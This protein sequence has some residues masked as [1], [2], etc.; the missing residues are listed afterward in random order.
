MITFFA[1]RSTCQACF[2]FVG[3]IFNLRD[4]VDF[5][6]L[7]VFSGR[8][9]A[10]LVSNLIWCIAHYRHVLVQVLAVVLWKPYKDCHLMCYK[11]T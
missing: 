10:D 1:K 2:A 7:H 9:R 4:V 8:F 6:P 5:G 3:G 11:V